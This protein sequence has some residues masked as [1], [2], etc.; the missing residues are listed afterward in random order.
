MTYENVSRYGK[1][2]KLNCTLVI[3]HGRT[4]YMYIIISK[5]L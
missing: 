1:F 3:V 5:N 4:W 2:I